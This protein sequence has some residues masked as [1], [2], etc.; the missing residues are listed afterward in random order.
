[1][2]GAGEELRSLLKP[3]PAPGL[4]RTRT[5]SRSKPRSS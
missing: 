1:L 2:D 5:R 3:D 4:T